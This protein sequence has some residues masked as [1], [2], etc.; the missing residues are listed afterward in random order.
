MLENSQLKDVME[1][2]K[3]PSATSLLLSLIELNDCLSFPLC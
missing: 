1:D 2:L 3:I